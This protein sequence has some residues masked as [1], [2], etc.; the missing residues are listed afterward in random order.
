MEFK[1]STESLAKT[2]FEIFEEIEDDDIKRWIGF[3]DKRLLL[4]FPRG[5]QCAYSAVDVVKEVITDV[6]GGNRNWDIKK[7]PNIN[8]FMFNQIRSKI[9][10]IVRKRKRIVDLTSIKKRKKEDEDTDPA[11][12]FIDNNYCTEKDEILTDFENKD[13]VKKCYEVVQEDDEAYLVLCDMHKDMTN[14]EIAE[15]L[16][17]TVEEVLKIKKRI[18]YRT[19][20]EL[21]KYY[22]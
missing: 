4:K 15:D 18:K 20:K 17:V 19:N 21:L 10:N 14:K 1:I 6:L 9:W 8:T 5:K 7:V 16:G 3:A 13:L 2:L 11:S 22:K 12:D